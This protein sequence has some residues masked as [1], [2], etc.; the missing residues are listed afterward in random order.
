M[1]RCRARRRRAFGRKQRVAQQFDGVFA[2]V[3]VMLARLVEHPALS[4]PVAPRVTRA[5]PLLLFVS[6]QCIC[7]FHPH[8]SGGHFPVRQRISLTPVFPAPTVPFNLS[9]LVVRWSKS[10]RWHCIATSG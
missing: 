8:S 1:A 7:R 6:L 2:V 10:L 5:Q 3:T 9:Q 4:L